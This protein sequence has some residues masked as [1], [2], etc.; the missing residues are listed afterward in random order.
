MRTSANSREGKKEIIINNRWEPTAL[1]SNSELSAIYKAVTDRMMIF[2]SYDLLDEKTPSIFIIPK[3]SAEMA[4]ILCGENETIRFAMNLI[5]N[6]LFD[7][8]EEGMIYIHE[9]THI[10][11]SRII[12]AVACIL[13]EKFSD[14]S[15]E[16]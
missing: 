15:S 6:E 7:P 16:D 14:D 12:R 3:G 5:S 8:K 11:L 13:R 10:E 9:D 2:F 1:F 4:W